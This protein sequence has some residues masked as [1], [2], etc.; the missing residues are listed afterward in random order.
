MADRPPAVY[1]IML[2]PGLLD[3]RADEQRV[4]RRLRARGVRVAVVGARDFGPFGFKTFGTDYNQMLGTYLRG[5]A[6]RV[7][8]VGDLASPA[9]GTY[10]SRGFEILHLRR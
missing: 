3:S 4:I 2:L 8:R 10:P 5:A 7:E 1:E 6:V 9:A